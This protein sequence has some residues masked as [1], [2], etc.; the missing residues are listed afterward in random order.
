MSRS[1]SIDIGDD[2]LASATESVAGFWDPM[3]KRSLRSRVPSRLKD[4]VFSGGGDGDDGGGEYRDT[5]R[6]ADTWLDNTPV[7]IDDE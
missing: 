7:G 3:Q 1:V 6:S 5:T 4:S 2:D